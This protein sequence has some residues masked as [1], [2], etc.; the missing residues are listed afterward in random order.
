MRAM[1]SISS[2]WMD[3]SAFISE[4]A[5]MLVMDFETMTSGLRAVVRKPRKE[6]VKGANWLA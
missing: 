5:I 6:V 3:G 1:A 4:L 2:R